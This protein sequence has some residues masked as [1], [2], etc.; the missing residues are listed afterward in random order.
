MDLV[1]IH[2]IIDQAERELS[3]RYNLHLVI[4][5]DPVGHES[6]EVKEVKKEVKSKIKKNTII[7]S[8]HDF[9]II[10]EDGQK[11]VIFHIVVDGNKID[12]RFSK[13]ELKDEVIEAIKE[14]NPK[15]SC[16]IVVDIE[17]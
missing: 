5:V 8:I 14:I 7:E 13:K 17:Y 3:E 16:D 11:C 10:E 12:K 2:N 9:N 1:T 4:H 6:K 15:L